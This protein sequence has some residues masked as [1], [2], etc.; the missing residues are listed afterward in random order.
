M[1]YAMGHLPLSY[2][3]VRLSE[4]RIQAPG[5]SQAL[6]CGKRGS[7][8]LHGQVADFSGDLGR[9]FCAVLRGKGAREGTRPFL[10]I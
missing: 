5:L 7:R 10:G 3:T 2:F 8:I 6:L 4:R 9:G 1:T